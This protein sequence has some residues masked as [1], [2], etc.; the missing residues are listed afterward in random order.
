MMFQFHCYKQAAPPGLKGNKHPY[1]GTL[2]QG[3]NGICRFLNLTRMPF[4]PSLRRVVNV[5]EAM[6]HYMFISAT[7]IHV[8]FF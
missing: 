4:I 1:R 7:N 6:T 3:V 5:V 2:K 8:S